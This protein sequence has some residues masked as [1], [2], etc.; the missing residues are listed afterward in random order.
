MSGDLLVTC[1]QVQFGFESYSNYQL[2]VQVLVLGPGGPGTTSIDTVN[3]GI[4]ST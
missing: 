3:Y 1:F 2:V 4:S